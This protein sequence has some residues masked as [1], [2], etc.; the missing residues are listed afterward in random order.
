MKTLQS[1]E[2]DTERL[3]PAL[4]GGLE[5]EAIRRYATDTED[6]VRLRCVVAIVLSGWERWHS[7][8]LN[9]PCAACAE[10]R[11][12]WEASAASPAVL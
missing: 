6:P 5:P 2:M 12:R 4:P 9:G 11:V 8:S 10:R 1:E 7:D 3:V